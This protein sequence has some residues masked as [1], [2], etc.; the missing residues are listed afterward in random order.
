M[1]DS[2]P[3]VNTSQIHLHVE[4]CSL[5]TNW[6]LAERLLCKQGCKKDAQR[7]RQEGKRSDQVGTCALGRGTQT[8]TVITRAEILPV[9]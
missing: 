8:S 9:E 3:P 1:G 2:R 7:I 4:Q 5:K 6:R